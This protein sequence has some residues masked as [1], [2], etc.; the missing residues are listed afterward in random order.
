MSK[1]AAAFIIKADIT[2]AALLGQVKKYRL[3]G[4]FVSLSEFANAFAEKGYFYEMNIFCHGQKGR[5]IPSKRTILITIIELF[6]QRGAITS[7]QEANE[8]L[9]SAEDGY[10]TNRE[11]AKLFSKTFLHPQANNL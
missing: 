1:G 11:Q 9:E 5:R 4:E 3:R 2:P 6:I 8:F 7:L 10:L